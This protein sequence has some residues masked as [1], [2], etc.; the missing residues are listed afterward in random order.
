MTGI[1]ADELTATYEI[2]DKAAIE[3]LA[4]G[5]FVSTPITLEDIETEELQASVTSALENSS[6][7]DEA[8]SILAAGALQTPS[9]QNQLLDMGVS[10]SEIAAMAAQP[11]AAAAGGGGRTKFVVEGVTVTPVVLCT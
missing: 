2:I 9:I 4:G 5:L 3:D 7:T 8:T 6:F 1:Q 11:L 10:Q